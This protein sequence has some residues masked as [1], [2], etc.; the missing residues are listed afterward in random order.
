MFEVKVKGSK[1]NKF[2]NFSAI[3]PCWD[4]TWFAITSEST[5]VLQKI[6]FIKLKS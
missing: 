4:S 6:Q 3:V 1:R 2:S 5:M